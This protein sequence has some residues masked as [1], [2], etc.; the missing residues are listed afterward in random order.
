[1]GI[2]NATGRLERVIPEQMDRGS[3]VEE[4]TSQPDL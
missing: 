3:L 1:M 2:F 4:T